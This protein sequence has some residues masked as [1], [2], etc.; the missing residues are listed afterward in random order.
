M[1][2]IELSD[3]REKEL[4]AILDKYNSYSAF[5]QNKDDAYE[6][7]RRIN[8]GICPY[9]NLC[10]LDLIEENKT[11]ETKKR[12]RSP[13]DH[14][15]PQSSHKGKNLELKIKNLVPACHTCNS[16]KNATPFNDKEYINPYFDD[17]DSIKRFEVETSG[18]Y[19]NPEHLTILIT[20]NPDHTGDSH[21][22]NR[23][24]ANISVFS[25]TTRYQEYKGEVVKLLKKYK[26]Y[27]APKINE[28]SK[29]TGDFDGLIAILL[30][31]VDCDISKTQ[32]GKL[33]RDLFKQY[34]PCNK[35]ILPPSPTHSAT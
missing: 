26:Y 13:F 22:F 16:L 3:K 14:W 6:V 29:L 4:Q 30:E 1:I 25:L 35:E 28:L 32:L 18:G 34:C 27:H 19:D 11:G 2:K 12:L 31:D 24:D 33:K 5:S 15:V 10:K 20:N 17:F 21:D 8:I 23:A 9:C 7:F